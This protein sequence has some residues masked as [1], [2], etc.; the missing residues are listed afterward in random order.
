MTKDETPKR[1]GIDPVFRKALD[2]LA[3]EPDNEEEIVAE[4]WA[5][6]TADGF[7]YPDDKELE[8]NGRT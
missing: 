4:F 8:K 2:R 7:E 3:A 1:I 5:T 6:V